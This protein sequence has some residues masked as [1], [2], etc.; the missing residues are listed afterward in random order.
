[1]SSAVQSPR[2][3]V[4]CVLYFIFL[5]AFCFPLFPAYSSAEEPETVITSDTLEYFHETQTYVA[6]G[7]VEVKK[8]DA[9]ITADEMTYNEA[10]SDLIAQG[11]VRYDD[12]TVSMKA[13][14]AELNLETN[15]GKLFDADIVYAEPKHQPPGKKI[16]KRGA[17]I[18]LSGK[19]IEKRGENVYY[20]PSASFTTCD[21]PVPAWCVR[22]RNVEA[23]VGERV[24]AQ[25]ASFRIKDVPVLYTPYLVAPILT[26]RQ[27]GFL[28]PL[29]SQSNTR[30][31][32]LKV[33]FFWAIAENRD[34]TFVLDTYSKRGIGEGLEYRFIEPGVHGNLWAY[35]IKDT[36]LNKDF[37]E[38]K[39][40]Y[41]N[42]HADGPG[43]FLNINIL[44]EKDFYQE[45]ALRLQ[46]SSQRYLESTG[47]IN[48]PFR[49]SRLY[50]LS[51]YWID[52]KHDTETVPQKLPEAGYVL[53]YTNLGGPLFSASLTA[54]NFWR[55]GGLS[56]GR[57][58]FYPKLLYSFGKDFTLSQTA[59]GRATAYSFYHDTAS[60]ES[61]ST[62]TAFEYD[63][64]GHTRLYK[65]YD[66]FWHVI[67]PSIGYHFVSSSDNDL[68]AFDVTELYKKT[69]LIELSLLNR[70]ISRGNEMATVRLTQ[71]I[72][73][74][75]GDQPFLPVRLEVG[76]NAWVPLKMDASFNTYTRRFETISSDLSFRIL[77][78]NL[79]FGQRY[80][81]TENI[82]VYTAGASFSPYR[83]IH[84][85]SSVWY[86]AEGEGIRDLSVTL[87]YLRQ[88]WGIRFEMH[89]R[90]GDFTALVLLELAGVN[91]Q[92]SEDNGDGSP[93]GSSP[94]PLTGR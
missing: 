59:A 43:G 72:D 69:S 78:A 61:S 11:K 91:S 90:T 16:E 10:T 89:K 3:L 33:P 48:I 35:H 23:V 57:V 54:D 26:E 34:A 87:R 53:N 81:R 85:A 41:E 44:N 71:E 46:T 80:N 29:V 7:S 70:I 25:D 37:L 51:Q 4:S 2:S 8:E 6:K 32:G 38:L 56:A 14:R 21:T 13:D 52:L 19:E 50:L 94:D 9:V 28:M 20:S 39:G 84:F 86:D 42:W 83:N 62:R 47:E 79:S 64:V 1:M 92:P 40:R 60:A 27:T 82:M 15:T 31:F 65:K 68:P 17:N 58:D 76:L 49:N 30:G 66:S 73:T 5:S 45:Y 75:N 67:E 93:H 12:P 77:K 55:D 22:G 36:E 18:Y 74:Y 88:C 24:K 63:V